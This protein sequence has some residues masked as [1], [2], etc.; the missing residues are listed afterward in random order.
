ML[1]A[2]WFIIAILGTLVAVG[3]ALGGE[4]VLAVK[5]ATQKGFWLQVSKIV[6]TVIGITARIVE[7]IESWTAHIGAKLAGVTLPAAPTVTASKPPSQA[8]K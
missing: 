3:L 2:A 8:T 4:Q 6:V 1:G 7:L 5:E